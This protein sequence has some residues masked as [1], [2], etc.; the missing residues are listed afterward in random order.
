MHQIRANGEAKDALF[1]QQ[2]A[3][4]RT[5]PS[6]STVLADSIKLWWAWRNK[7]NRPFFRS[8]LLIFLALLTTAGTIS[9]SI[10]SSLVVDSSDL[11]VLVKS[12]FCGSPPPKDRSDRANGYAPVVAEAA[13]KYG[14]LC[15]RDFAAENVTVAQGCD[16]FV[17]RYINFNTS[18]EDCPF[19]KSM[20]VADR[21]GEAF[22]MDSLL[23]DA[24]KE[25]GL[26]LPADSEI[27]YRR[28]TTCSVLSVQNHTKIYNITDYASSG[29]RFGNFP[30]EQIFSLQYG[31]NVDA[32]GNNDTQTT[33][34]QAANI[35][36]EYD[37]ASV[38][39]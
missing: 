21:G 23:L 15:S 34:I 14:P 13:E 2:Q 6:P 9:A 35:S 3:L 4:L 7:T 26:N 1:R 11:T 32:R 10:F 36:F 16:A 8:I 25:F 24:N 27:R 19:E 37:L 31:R 17:N 18:R 20:C 39:R 12:P 30:D 22:V 33:S 38:Q 28:K 5:L 29:Y